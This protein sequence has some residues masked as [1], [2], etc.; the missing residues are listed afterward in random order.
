M[1]G[2]PGR[3]TLDL[4]HAGAAG[5]WKEQRMRK[6]MFLSAAVLAFGVGLAG[7]EEEKSAGDG[8]EEDDDGTTQTTTS[9]STST[10][11]TKTST[12]TTTMTMT[13]TMTMPNT[14]TL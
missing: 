2:T 3:F 9:T 1:A 12:S 13:M 6:W 14:A 5:V 10:T 4:V 8:E 7:C 11:T